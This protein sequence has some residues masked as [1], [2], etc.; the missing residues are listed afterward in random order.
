[1]MI[2]VFVPKTY[3]TSG[4][5]NKYPMLDSDGNPPR[6]SEFWLTRPDSWMAADLATI[7]V[8]PKT[9]DAWNKINEQTKGKQLLK[10]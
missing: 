1:M 9:W 8:S 7:S 2:T 6:P 4:P 5:T 10:G 3:I